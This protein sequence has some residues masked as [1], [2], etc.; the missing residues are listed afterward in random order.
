MIARWFLSLLLLVLTLS[1]A[2]PPGAPP[3]PTTAQPIAVL[4][5]N[6]RTG[7][8]LLVE[9]ASFCIPMRIV[10][11]ASPSLMSWRR[12]CGAARTARCHG[13]CPEAV[14]AAIGRQTPG[15]PEE[16]VALAAQAS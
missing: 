7:D 12:R 15:S 16:A 11:G 10:L 3:L 2:L 14:V 5:P 13:H 9:S 6:N 1:C 8:P 4:P